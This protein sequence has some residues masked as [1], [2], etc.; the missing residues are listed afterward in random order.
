MR[1]VF[2]KNTPGGL[3]AAA[4]VCVRKI[5]S[6]VFFPHNKR[7]GYT[8]PCVRFNRFP[9]EYTNIQVVTRLY[10]A[11]YPHLIPLLCPQGAEPKAVA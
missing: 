4:A 1:M 7:L 8:L 10:S 2:I 11:F 6:D 3:L 9:P 5:S